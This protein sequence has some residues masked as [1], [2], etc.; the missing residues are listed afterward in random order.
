MTEVKVHGSVC[1]GHDAGNDAADWFS[2]YLG[3]DCRLVSYAEEQPRAVNSDYAQ[4]GDEVSFADGLPV[5]VTS[6]SSL[7]ALQPEF[8]DALGSDLSMLRFRP[9]IVIQ[10]L[11]AF[12]EDVIHTVRIGS[13]LVLEFMKPCERCVVPSIDLTSGD[14]QPA[15]TR[16]L[17]D[18]RFGHD[19]A[20]GLK[21][22]FFGQSATPRQLGVVHHGDEVE[23]LSTRPVSSGIRKYQTELCCLILEKNT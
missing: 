15:V 19:R 12:Q 10:G 11:P 3:R 14:K 22:A 7:K 5:L 4:E 23:V 6:E 21:G 13:S 1:Y 18:N 20:S 16:I 17:R 2:N 8:K 9:N